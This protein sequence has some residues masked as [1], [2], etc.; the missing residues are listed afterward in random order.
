LVHAKIFL[1]IEARLIKGKMVAKP[2]NII[3]DEKQGYITR[4]GY[5]D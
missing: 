4:D 3:M 2:I 5:C 1:K